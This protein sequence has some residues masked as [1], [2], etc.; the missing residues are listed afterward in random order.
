MKLFPRAFR[1]TAMT[2]G[3]GVVLIF[4]SAVLAAE[5]FT[6]DTARVA[7]GKGDP[8]AQFFLARHYA[9][10][11]GVPLDYTKSIKY[12]QQAAMHGYAPAQT[13]FGSCYANGQGVQQDFA[14]AVQWYRKAALQNDPMAEYCLGHA[15]ADGV[16]ANK[17]MKQGLTWWQR[18]AAQGQ[19]DAENALGNYYLNGENSGDT[20]HVNYAEATQWLR[21]AAE[22]GYASAMGT[23]G[24]MYLYGI[25]VGQDWAQAL[26]WNRRAA[27]LND[28][29]GQDNLGQ[30]YENGQA[31]LSLDL[32][33]AYKWFWLSDQQGNQFAKHDVFEIE[34]HHA[35][36]PQR[37][38]EAKHLAAEF[39]AQLHEKQSTPTPGADD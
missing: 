6:L 3:M 2:L 18:A 17:D 13:G 32:V 1:A 33:Q 4:E 11:L 28:A 25:G 30:M 8:R 14:E 16:G 19:A 9:H 27:E 23:L 38:A 37:I 21:K 35:L 10:G 12:L 24:Y 15:Y 34:T 22:Q 36:T 29:A 26:R 20:N 7:A 5:T 31:G 39:R